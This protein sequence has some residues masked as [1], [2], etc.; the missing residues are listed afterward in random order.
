MLWIDRNGRVQRISERV[1]DFWWLRL[2]PDNRRIA[3][4]ARANANDEVWTFDIERDA[5]ARL[6]FGWNSQ[7]PFWTPDS[8]RIVF[9]SDRQGA[10]N[11]FWQPADGSTPPERLL[12]SEHD[13]SPLSCSPDGK[14]LAFMDIGPT[15]SADIW[16]LSLDGDRR[17]RPF[18]SESFNENFAQFSPDGHWIAS[19]PTRLADWKCMS[20]RTR[21]GRQVA[22][23]QRRLHISQMESPRRR[24]PVS[25]RASA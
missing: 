3:F 23:I 22:G 19:D 17:P 15:N 21:P 8:A 18:V 24:T 20:V 13:Q 5:F 7:S 14:V 11:L 16:T 12:E 9:S 25:L 2:S 1:N 6:A 10:W 4:I